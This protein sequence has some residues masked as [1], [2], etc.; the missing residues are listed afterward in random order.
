MRDDVYLPVATGFLQHADS[1]L[2]AHRLKA[3]LI[4]HWGR[5]LISFDEARRF[6][7]LSEMTLR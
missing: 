6:L 3:T 2:E 7:R 5:R 4:D 1:L